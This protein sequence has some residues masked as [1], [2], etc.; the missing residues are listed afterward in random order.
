NFQNCELQSAVDTGFNRFSVGI[1]SLD[2]SVNAF[3]GRGH[4]RATSIRAIE[5]L[6]D[7]GLP[8]NADIMFGLPRQ[9]A[10]TVADD[11]ELLIKLGVP[12]ITIYRLRNVERHKMGIGNKSAWNNA[13]VRNRMHAAGDF[14]S[15][16]E[17]YAMREAI[18]DVFIRYNYRPS[19]CG[20]WS[21]PGT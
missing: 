20:W 11:V 5:K 21:A 6:I 2:T 1:Q 13:K 16:E 4:D 17:T 15:L 19:P 18:V 14:P 3:A 10:E 8:F 7:T 9:S 12:T